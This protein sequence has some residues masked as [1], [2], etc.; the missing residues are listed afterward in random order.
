MVAARLATLYLISSGTSS[1]TER[2]RCLVVIILMY[3]AA[4]VAAE[5]RDSSAAK[6]NFTRRLVVSPRKSRSASLFF[7]LLGFRNIDP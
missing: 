7:A 5:V 1:V 2:V 4:E 3:Q 6:L